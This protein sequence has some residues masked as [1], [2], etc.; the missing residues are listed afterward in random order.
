[1]KIK[2]C[3][4]LSRWKKCK[5]LQIMK[6]SALLMVVFTLKISA[7][8]FG[9]FSFTA[10]GKTAR[11]IFDI[12][13]KGSNYRFFYNDE[14]ESVNKIVSLEVNNTDINNVLDKVLETTDYTYKVFENNLVVI[15]LKDDIREQADLQQKIVR[16]VVNDSNGNP[17]PGVSVVIKGTTKGTTTDLN[18]NYVL[19]G[20][21][22]QSVL[23]VSFIG[24]KLRKSLLATKR[25]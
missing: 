20:V 18:G 5:I 9:Q 13:E 14:F 10:E 17:A 16:G 2:I 7:V 1:M 24:L 11:E 15:S 3:S 22:S 4:Y 21:D 25:K 6:I 23:L 12:I 19:E 8:G